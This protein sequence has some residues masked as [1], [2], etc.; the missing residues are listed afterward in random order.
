MFLGIHDVFVL[1]SA[2]QFFSRSRCSVGA[3]DRN[4]FLVSFA[5]T[6]EIIAFLLYPVCHTLQLKK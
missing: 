4:V 3:R 6:L 1:Q 5:F 2:G